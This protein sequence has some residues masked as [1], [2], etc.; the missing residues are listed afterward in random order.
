MR[1]HRRRTWGAPLR[2]AERGAGDTKTAARKGPPCETWRAALPNG[3]IAWAGASLFGRRLVDSH[4]TAVDEHVLDRRLL[5]EQVA[6]GHDQVC[7]LS[8]LQRPHAIGRAGDRGGIDRQRAN[9]GI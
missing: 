3:A 2:R 5:A 7:D 1:A 4:R 6:V 8:L 9:R